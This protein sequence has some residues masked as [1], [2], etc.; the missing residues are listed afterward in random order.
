M[1]ASELTDLSRLAIHTITNKPWSLQECIEHYSAAGVPGITVW[2]NVV[3]PL[4]PKESARRLEASGLGVVALVRGGFFPARESQKRQDAIDANKACLDEAAALG[5]RMVVLVCGA[6]PGM[7]LKEARKQIRDGI[8]AVLPHAESLGVKLAIEPLH[9]M[10]ADERSAVCT[11]GQAREIYESIEHPLVGTA[12][13]VYHVWWDPDLQEEIAAAGAADRLFAFHVC[14]WRVPTRHMLTDRG[15]MGEGCIDIP[16]IRG[17]VEEAG[18][19][20]WIEVEI[21][22]EEY[23]AADQAAYLESIKTAYLRHV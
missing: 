18:F 10:Y 9:P 12:V 4:G 13:D 11:M 16:Q 15:L 7:P 5:A 19:D 21:F 20:G 22:S 8:E 14:D 3:E 23:W 6:V 1:A 2:R 17:W